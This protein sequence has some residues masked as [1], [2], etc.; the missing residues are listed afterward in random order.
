MGY[1][2]TNREPNLRKLGGR[3]PQPP[4][5]RFH[6]AYI[7][8][9]NGCWQWQGAN[10]GQFGYGGITVNKKR[11][12]AHRYSW[13]LYNG[14]ITGDLCVLHKCD[15]PKCV[16]PDHLFLGTQ[17]ENMED[18]KN[19]G[20]TNGGTKTPLF[21]TKNPN[22]KLTNRDIFQIRADGRPQRAIAK[23]YKISQCLVHNIK[24][25]KTWGH[26]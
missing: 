2:N 14:D 8:T 4:E 13:V 3:N 7:K 18:C 25:L 23:D 24:T 17:K 5:V 21:G 11:I 16:N 9:D 22:S 19:K 1:D 26:I 10:E 20:R 15:N 6:N 12:M